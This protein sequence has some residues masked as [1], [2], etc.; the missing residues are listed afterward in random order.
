LSRKSAFG[1]MH[2][3]YTYVSPASRVMSFIGPEY[4]SYSLHIRMH[5]LFVSFAYFNSKYYK[6]SHTIIRIGNPGRVWQP[7]RSELKYNG[8][9]ARFKFKKSA[10]NSHYSTICS[11]LPHP[12]RS[13]SRIVCR[14]REGP[15]GSRFTLRPAFQAK[16]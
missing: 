16:A 2:T 6:N 15:K 8:C 10:P 7:A 5:H 12:T 4:G 3:Q 9:L 1:A 11:G 13:H 14:G